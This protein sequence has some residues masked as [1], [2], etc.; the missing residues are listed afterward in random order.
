[1][2]NIFR[3][4][5]TTENQ[6]LD[7]NEPN[8]KYTPTDEEEFDSFFSE[9]LKRFPA[10]TASIILTSYENS[11]KMAEKILAQSKHQLEASFNTFLKDVDDQT[12]KQCHK[13]I[14][15]AS[16]TAAIIGCSPIPFSDA[17]LLVPVQLTMMSHLH[18]LFGQSW[19]ESM[20][21]SLSKELIIVGLGKS[22]VGNIVKFIPGVGTVT[23]AAINAT[24]ASTITEALGW[25]TVK[26]LNDGEDIFD[27]VTTFKGQYKT[28]VKALRKSSK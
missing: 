25:V 28:L 5:T 27:Q 13:T 21:K 3:K 9:V 23:G 6:L 17:F 8:K 18:K 24:V 12:R 1:M 11:K 20:G 15:S 10:K 14:H 19:S 22:T 26:M 7:I 4:N 16:L 2:K